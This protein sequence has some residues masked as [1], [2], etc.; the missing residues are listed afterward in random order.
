MPRIPYVTE[1]EASGRVREL[2]EDYAAEH[3][4]RSLMRASLA[5]HPPLLEVCAFFFEWVMRE[6][7]LDRKLKETVAVVVSQTNGCAYCAAS[8]RESLVE[9]FG[10]PADRVEAVRSMALPDL[11]ARERAAAEFAAQAAEDPHRLTDDHF[12]ALYDAGFSPQNVV[13][14]LGVV[15]LFNFVNT[16]GI[17]MDL[18]PEDRDAALPTY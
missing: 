1:A 15:G 17:A 9:V 6:G 7:E 13:E 16:Y 10:L 18:Q 4:V 3:G 12:E 2:L 11:P 8:H 5:N 14:L